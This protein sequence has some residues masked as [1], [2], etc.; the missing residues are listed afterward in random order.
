[1]QFLNAV[2][3]VRKASWIE[4]VRAS[5]IDG[6]KR[7]PSGPPVSATLAE[8]QATLPAAAGGGRPAKNKTVV[9]AMAGTAKQATALPARHSH[10]SLG[11]RVSE[12]KLALGVLD[13]LLV[14]LALIAALTQVGEF[15][16]TAENLLGN[17]KWFIT[18]AIVW[19]ASAVFFDCYSL[20]RAASAINSARNSALAVAA[21]SI[22]YVLI[23][24]LTPPLTTRGVIFYFSGLALVLITL[25]RVAYARIFVQPWFQQRAIIVGAGTAGRVMAS[26]MRAAPRN[27]ANPYRGTGY[28]LVGFID[29]NGALHDQE[30]EGVTVLGNN[31]ALVQLA[32][33][34]HVS[35]I[36]LAITNTQEI[37]DDMLNAL[38][39]CRELG[40]RVV[41]MA[42]IYERM[43]GRVAIDFV[44]RELQMVLPMEDRAGERAFKVAKRGM[45]VFLALCGLLVMSFFLV[46][47]AIVNRLTSPGPLFYTQWR[48]G[49]GGKIF[50]MYKF[51][52]MR[53]NAEQG[54]GAVWARQGDSRITL[55]GNFAR[56]SRIDELPQ[57]I[58]VLKGDMSIVGPRPERPEFVNALSLL[59]P[60]YRAR[61]AVKPGITGWAQIKYGYGGTHQEARIK[62]E[63]DLYYVKHASVLLDTYVL[64]QTL[65][66]MLLGKGT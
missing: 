3:K 30:I 32:Q 23:P 47:I 13:I 29:D 55:V 12:R 49:Q 40:F 4:L 7:N 63:H 22:A 11:L 66:V 59:V 48:V 25:W 50:K 42:T 5:M 6:I 18:L 28:E 14:N 34:Q 46:P 19:L 27:D 2:K 60:Y 38:L 43:T 52:S 33:L 51:R 36:I 1:M 58:N 21:T 56:K 45:D 9:G 16:P 17:A 41:T 39:Q 37:S 31:R 61:H 62:L 57:C 10:S 35:E 53:P 44:G 26:A 20:A 54:T 65:P 64:L 24:F 8:H 15:A